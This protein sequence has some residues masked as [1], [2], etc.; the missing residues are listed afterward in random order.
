MRWLWIPALAATVLLVGSALNEG[1]YVGAAAYAV[2]GGAFSWWLSP[3]QGMRG[4][5]QADVEQLPAG[6][7]P[8][9]IYW[10]QGC[11]YCTRLRAR[12]GRA[13]RQALWVN[14]WKD[15]DAAAFVRSVNGGDETVPTVVVDGET[16]TNP[17]PAAVRAAL[18]R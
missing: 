6:E 1:S 18:P 17:D 12:L 7:L 8:V 3:W 13:G 15:P 5:C 16:S 4:V 2:V 14:I 9:V 10:R 11:A